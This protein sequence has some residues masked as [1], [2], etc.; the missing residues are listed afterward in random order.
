[1]INQTS[2]EHSGALGRCEQRDGFPVVLVGR[3]LGAGSL[4]ASGRGVHS[5]DAGG[6][7][8]CAGPGVGLLRD[9]VRDTSSP[10]VPAN[11]AVAVR[12]V[13]SH[14]AGLAAGPADGPGNP[15]L[16]Q[17]RLELRAVRS[18]AFSDE[19]RE[20]SAASVRAQVD[21]GGEPC[22]PFGTGA[23]YRTGSSAQPEPATPRPD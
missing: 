2:R 8:E 7:G 12:L 21:L 5:R 18:L 22:V 4:D 15:D 17:H 16:V 23:G 6:S 19:R 3:A 9:C 14:A 10:Q 11:E 13:R 20:W 1:M